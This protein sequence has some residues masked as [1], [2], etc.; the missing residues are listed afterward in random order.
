[1]AIFAEWIGQTWGIG[2]SLG[3]GTAEVSK[4]GE[5]RD[6]QGEVCGDNVQQP[7]SRTEDLERKLLFCWNS[8]ETETESAPEPSPGTKKW[9]RQDLGITLAHNQRGSRSDFRSVLLDEAAPLSRQQSKVSSSDSAFPF[10]RRPV[11]QEEV[12]GKSPTTF[13]ANVIDCS[14]YKGLLYWHTQCIISPIW[15][16]NSLDIGGISQL[17]NFSQVRSVSNFHM[18]STAWI[19]KRREEREAH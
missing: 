7:I 1:M 14:F 17:R 6:A 8:T 5:D 3:T 4:H 13:D 19:L 10:I 16:S 18:I 9:A 15:N 2:I 11:I 12:T